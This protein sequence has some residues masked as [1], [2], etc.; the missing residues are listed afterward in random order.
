VELVTAVVNLLAHA[1]SH[2]P[3][4]PAPLALERLWRVREL[5]AASPAER[6]S[7]PE[8]E[9]VCGLDRWTL[10]RQFRT[11]FGTSPSRFRTMRQLDLVRRSLCHGTSLVAASIEAGFADQ[12]HMSRHFKSAYGLTPGEWVSAAVA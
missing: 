7:L 3:P 10:A 2:S 11:A 6:R 9:R 12:S 5:I 1:S 4:R 8:L